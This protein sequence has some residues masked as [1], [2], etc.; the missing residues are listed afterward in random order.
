MKS[1]QVISST[2][3]ARSPLNLNRRDRPSQSLHTVTVSPHTCDVQCGRIRKLGFE[4]SIGSGK[5]TWSNFSKELP[6]YSRS[7]PIGRAT[8]E[9]SIRAPHTP[10][11]SVS[12]ARAM[13]LRTRRHCSRREAPVRFPGETPSWRP[14]HRRGKSIALGTS[15][16]E[17]SPPACMAASQAQ[18]I[19]WERSTICRWQL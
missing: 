8:Q 11:C 14:L 18:G 3:T 13:R 5:L 6:S 7:M 4:Y 15:C 12:G 17:S 19:V 1:S 16:A 10:M 9:E 2:Q